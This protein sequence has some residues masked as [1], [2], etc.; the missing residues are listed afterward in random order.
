MNLQQILKSSP[1]LDN[2]MLI[3]CTIMEYMV[4]NCT[5][6]KRGDNYFLILKD[7]EPDV[8]NKI[9]NVD[10]FVYLIILNDVIPLGKVR[11]FIDS[12]AKKP[13]IFLTKKLNDLWYSLWVSKT[14]IKVLIKLKQPITVV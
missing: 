11:I 2:I 9:S 7:L 10:Y 14:P 8:M 4:K 5:I 1:H 6:Y 13:A 12:G 3:T